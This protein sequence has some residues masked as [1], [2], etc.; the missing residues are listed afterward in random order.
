M[1]CLTNNWSCPRPGR[2]ARRAFTFIEL[3]V[4]IALSIVLL[5]G[6][7]TIFHSA[8]SLT[9]LSEQKMVTMLEMAAVF[10][11]VTDD[12]ARSPTV[13]E[14]YFLDIPSGKEYIMF[15]AMR[16]DGVI[17]KHVYV[18]YEWTAATKI[19]TRVVYGDDML[20]PATVDAD[21]EDGE[22]MTVARNVAEFKVE[23]FNNTEDA[24]DDIDDDGADD[25]WTTGTLPPASPPDA[26]TDDHLRT[27]A[28]KFVIKI[29]N[30]EAG[31]ADLKEQE[32]TLILP[33]MY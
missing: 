21:G 2:R 19:L 5:R 23:Y 4:A 30:P 11:Y 14:N 9:M 13:S 32:F 1:K 18:K 20:N 16:V 3:V 25:A 7:Y 10:D 12:I 26:P 27:R 17:G 22:E 33:V 8:T 15:Q 29:E 6:M 31:P 24:N 28:V